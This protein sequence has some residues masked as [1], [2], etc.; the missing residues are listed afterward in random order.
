MTGKGGK[1][2]RKGGFISGGKHG[3]SKPKEAKQHKDKADQIGGRGGKVN[4]DR[5]KQECDCL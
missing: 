4:R 2:R 5:R 1:E 3:E